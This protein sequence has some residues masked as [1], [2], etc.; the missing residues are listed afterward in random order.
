MGNKNMLNKFIK[1]WAREKTSRNKL[2]GKVGN[3]VQGMT[4]KTQHTEICEF[5][6]KWC[7]EEFFLVPICLN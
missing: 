6:L 2:L 4:T 1:W 7:L 5:Q 3:N